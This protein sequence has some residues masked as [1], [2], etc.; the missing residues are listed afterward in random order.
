MVAGAANRGGAHYVAMAVDH[1]APVTRSAY[2]GTISPRGPDMYNMWNFLLIE[3]G[4]GEAVRAEMTKQAVSAAIG[5]DDYTA[6]E[7][8]QR[9]ARGY[10]ARE[11]G[12]L[13][14][15][16]LLG[17]NRPADWPGPALVHRGFSKDDNQ[18]HFWLRWYD[19]MTADF[20]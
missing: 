19:M 16:A 8:I 4:A 7:S 10:I 6:W 11:R 17:E 12:R 13:K 20:A 14:Y 9:S 3:K 1:K 15:N 2:L 5:A 18:W